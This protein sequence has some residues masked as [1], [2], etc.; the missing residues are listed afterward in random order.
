MIWT[1]HL[2]FGFLAALLTKNLVSTGNIYV[3]F[4]LVLLGS[5]MPDVDQPNSKFNQTLKI[6]KIIGYIF[7]HRGVF[8]TLLF[9]LLLPG[10]VYFFIGKSYGT[11]LFIGYLSHL[12]IDGLTVAGVDLLHPLA[13]FRISGFVETGTISEKITLILIIALI[14]IELL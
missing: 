5:I 7:K 10:L 11:A 8:H 4:A 12:L 1:T 6:T 14:I 13:K 3:F 9:A 2:A